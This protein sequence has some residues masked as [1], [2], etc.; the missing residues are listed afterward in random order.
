MLAR[1][2]RELAKPSR[3]PSRLAFQIRGK[4][5]TDGDRQFMK[6]AGIEPCDFHDLLPRALTSPPG[7][8]P[9][10]LSL[11]E[12]DARWLRNLGILWEKE[13][14]PDFVPP[15]TFKEYLSRYPN[16]I[17]EA[18]EKVAGELGLARSGEGLDG[19]AR[20]IIAM[21]QDFVAGDLEDIVEMYP[22]HGL[23]G[24]GED[25]AAHFHHYIRFRV[26]AALQT[27]LEYEPPSFL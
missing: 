23:V 2:P 21:F 22:F 20:D 13:P 25:G 10:I 18:V 17:R 4:Q 12:K 14:E 27:L 6:E 9:T 16:G 7:V 1:N 8:G 24:P 11:T 3:N 19:L 15:R 5:M 26:K